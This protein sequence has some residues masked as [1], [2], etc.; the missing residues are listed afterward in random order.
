M[1]KE[2]VAAG[3]QFL[4]FTVISAVAIS[5]QQENLIQNPNANDGPNHWLGTGNVAVERVNGNPHFVLRDGGSYVQ[6]IVLPEGSAGEY[7]LLI[8]RGSSERINP[9]GAITGLPYLYG[10]MVEG[11]DPKGGLIKEYLQGQH[12]GS[13]SKRRDE[14]ATLWGI[15]EVPRGTGVIRFFLNQALRNGVPHNGSAARFDDLGLYLFDTAEEAKVYVDIYIEGTRYGRNLASPS[16]PT[17]L[18]QSKTS[19]K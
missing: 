7:A 11:N 6:N 8:G 10:Y 3:L 18:A 15:F 12:M 16:T 9:D 1:F 17:I 19:S 4:L 5:A 14:W 2:L 13:G